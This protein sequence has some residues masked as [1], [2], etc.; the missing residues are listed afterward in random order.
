MQQRD[1]ERAQR[2]HVEFR[3]VDV[4]GSVQ[5]DD[6]G[7]ERPGPVDARREGRHLAGGEGAG[8]GLAGPAEGA[9]GVDAVAHGGD[10]DLWG[11]VRE[12]GRWAWKEV[13]GA[14]I[15]GRTRR[16]Q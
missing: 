3:I 12:G 16:S 9:V 6:G 4:V 15:V 7:E 13:K 2:N 8:V 10:G 14:L 5:P 1:D 11:G